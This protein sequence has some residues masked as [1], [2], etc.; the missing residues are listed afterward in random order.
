[1]G[2]AFGEDGNIPMIGT[3][4]SVCV[5]ILRKHLHLFGFENS[6]AIYD[7]KDQEILIKRILESMSLDP[8]RTSPKAVLS[9]ISNAKN[10]LIGP[11]EYR[12][13]SSD[14]FSEKSR[15][16]IR[17]IRKIYRKI[18]RWILMTL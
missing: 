8:K 11:E 12:Q 7:E 1:M 10:Q 14:Y 4:H 3:F 9:H 16:F 17:C 18:T 13:Y 15:K 2:T 5:K 6:F